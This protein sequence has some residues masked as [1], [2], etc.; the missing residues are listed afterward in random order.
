MVYI[1]T[2]TEYRGYV[3]AAVDWTEEVLQGIVPALQILLEAFFV[4][5]LGA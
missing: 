3:V 1:L 4:G 5:I 2:P